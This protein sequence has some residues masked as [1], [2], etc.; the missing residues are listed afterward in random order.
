M[1]LTF[2]LELVTSSSGVNVYSAV[3]KLK[4]IN[5]YPNYQVGQVEL[6]NKLWE[7]DKGRVFN[8][9]KNK[10]LEYFSK[11]EI[12]YLLIPPTERTQFTQPLR[13]SI[14]HNFPNCIDLTNHFT[15]QN[16]VSFGTPPYSEMEINE[17]AEYIT[18]SNDLIFDENITRVLIADDTYS[19]GKTMDVLESILMSCNEN[20]ELKAGTII[21][22]QR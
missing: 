2:R 1:E 10:M 21:R 18:I 5:N 17:L 12:F 15:K 8:K 4:N 9:F 7:T 14:L 20:L 22:T 6:M 13:E 16:G 19:Q 3:H 11:E